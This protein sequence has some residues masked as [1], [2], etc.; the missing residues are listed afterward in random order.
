MIGNVNHFVSPYLDFFIFLF[1]SLGPA[2]CLCWAW[3]HKNELYLRMF[4]SCAQYCLGCKSVEAKR[5]A[6]AVIYDPLLDKVSN[7]FV[8]SP[9]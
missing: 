7:D 2:I 9:S 1:V 5:S 4:P 6:S 8:Q 3:Q